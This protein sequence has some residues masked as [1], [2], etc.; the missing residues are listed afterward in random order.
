MVH[1]FVINM[2]QP[3][4]IVAWRG[5]YVPAKVKDDKIVRSSATAVH[6]P[7]ELPLPFGSQ[8]CLEVIVNRNQP[9]IESVVALA[10]VRAEELGAA[11]FLV[12]QVQRRRPTAS[13]SYYEVI[14]AQTQAYIRNPDVP[15]PTDRGRMPPGH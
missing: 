7:G 5:Q 1:I 2:G 10:R 13:P 15:E 4:L 9:A 3:Q 6:L 8:E 12:D 11:Y 14:S